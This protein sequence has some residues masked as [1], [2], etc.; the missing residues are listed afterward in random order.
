[1]MQLFLFFVLYGQWKGSFTPRPHHQTETQ[2]E[3][4]VGEQK[5]QNIH[6]I[7]EKNS[8][9]YLMSEVKIGQ[10]TDITIFDYMRPEELYI[11]TSIKSS[12]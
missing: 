11:S 9:N 4:M 1:M 8:R 2:T 6:A 5:R 10:V 3:H 12:K 7:L